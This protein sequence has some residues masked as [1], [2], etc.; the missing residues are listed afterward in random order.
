MP[1]LRKDPVIGRWVI[2][3]AE[4]GKR[5]SD[6]LIEL[7]RKKGGFCPFCEGNED[8]TPPEVL[9]YRQNNSSPNKPGWKIRV[10]SNKYPALQIEGELNRR[11]YGVYDFMSGVGAHEV[12]IETPD[13]NKD[14]F[15]LEVGHI[16]D[17]WWAIRDR[18]LDLKKDSRFEYILVFKNHGAAAGAS[19]EH[20]HSQLIATPIIPKRVAEEL[21]GFRKHYSYKERCIFCDMIR[22]EKETGERIVMENDG[23]IAFEP[24]APRFPF[25]TWVLPK[26]HVMNFENSRKEDYADLAKILKEI[27]KRINRALAD[28]PYNFMIH[29]GPLKNDKY[30][31][32]HWHMEIIPKLT[33]VAGFEWGSGFYINPTPPEDAAKF[34]REIQF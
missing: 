33:K 9:A 28:P 6:F 12:I 27:I 5:P 20:T 17:V 32:F 16:E 3:S 24:F 30:Y 15:D 19:L 8:K 13:H 21:E 22:Q 10:V 14:L 2:I 11:G 1:E 29:T 18:V 26:T 25:E 34:L 31:D 7:E 4:R 23:F